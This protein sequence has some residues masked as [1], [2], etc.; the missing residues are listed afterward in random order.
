[1]M[2]TNYSPIWTL[3]I[4][5]VAGWLA[6][7]F[8]E[9]RGFGMLGD[10]IVGVLGAIVGAWC[11]SFLGLSAYGMVGLLLMAFFGSIVLLGLI[12]VVKRA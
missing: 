4:G 6:G 3:L 8:M 11:F 9:G 7:L 12:G 10:I 1:M 2:I 5:L